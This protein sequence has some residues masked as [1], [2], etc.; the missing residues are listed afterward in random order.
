MKRVLVITYWSYREPLVQNYT[1][2]YIHLM[3]K[4]LPKG[5]RIS[6]ITMEKP[7]QRLGGEQKREE[8]R[9]LA[10]KGIDWTS[11]RYDRF[12]LSAAFRWGS[13]ILRW[14]LKGR[15]EKGF[16]AVHAWGTPAGGPA[17]WIARWSGTP[18]I[19]DSFEPHAESMVEAGQWKSG[20]VA[21][22]FLLFLEKLQARGAEA[23]LGVSPTMEA[24]S[25]NR[26]RALHPSFF[27]KPAC[28]DLQSFDEQAAEH[29]DISLGTDG[30]VV[31]IYAGKFGGIYLEEEVF[32][33]I[34]VAYEEWGDQLFF[35]LLTD[36]TPEKVLEWMDLKG[37]PSH[38]IHC[39]WAEPEKVPA[40]L[41]KA[42]FALNP[43]R[44]LPSKRHCTSIKDGE[45][46]ASGL[47][48]MIPEGVGEDHRIIRE[49]GIGVVLDRRL[50]D[51]S[52]RKGVKE[53]RGVLEEGGRELRER[54]RRTAREERGF[55]RAEKAYR[56]IY[57][58]TLGERPLTVLLIAY[59]EHDDPVFHSALLDYFKGLAPKTELRSLLITFGDELQP[60]VKERIEAEWVTEGIYWEHIPSKEQDLK[61]VQKGSD[62]LKGVQK[63]KKMARSYKADLIYSEGFPSAILGHHVAN[64][65]GLPHVTHTFEPHADYMVEA[66]IWSAKGWE[67]R[68]NRSYERK[69]GRSADLLITGTERMRERIRSIPPKGEVLRLPSCVDL[70]MFRFSSEGRKEVRERYGIPP[71]SLVLTYL[72]KLGGMYYDRELFDLF[73]TFCEDYPEQDPRFMIFT[74]MPREEVRELAEKAGVDPTRIVIEKLRREDVPKYLSAGDVG[75]SGVRQTPSKAY[76]S[77]IKH[78]EY[79]GCGLPLLIFRGVSEDDQL[80]ENE[81]SGVVIEGADIASYRKAVAKTRELMKEDPDLLRDR[82]RNTAEKERSLEKAREVLRTTLP[83]IGKKQ[84]QSSGKQL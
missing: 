63:G 49:K 42:H 51:P 24:Y 50:D 59:Y 54:I 20:S 22:R 75:L 82:C 10:N 33:I 76:C 35:I 48:V 44:P 12:G 74:G 70:S 65:T 66:G 6:L 68:V 8:V 9:K 43:V 60:E 26:Y 14:V 34:R 84:Q 72:G 18:L 83:S 28:V 21:H 23:V 11:G 62:F 52:I 40:Y 32:D 37:I 46:W 25:W 7:E 80:V 79:W 19:I 39:R 17:Y 55:E 31:G 2:P 71:V 77:P 1:L 15:G 41:A 16:D 36:L 61:L 38:V 53:M 67:C 3:L 47:P 58:G 57:G 78:G 27:V 45:Y 81:G 30:K 5:S 69:V 73:R 29:K 4:I 13:V 64:A 56:K